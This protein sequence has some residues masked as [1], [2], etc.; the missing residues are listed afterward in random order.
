[1]EMNKP[2]VRTQ[3]ALT[4]GRNGINTGRKTHGHGGLRKSSRVYTRTQCLCCYYVRPATALHARGA[5]P[6]V[7]YNAS[8]KHTLLLTLR[9]LPVY[10][11]STC[12]AA[13][14]GEQD[15]L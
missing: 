2:A 15:W 5:A 6:R 9:H 8:Q 3:P 11:A 13:H 10:F 7:Q 12:C 14:E 4:K 1:M